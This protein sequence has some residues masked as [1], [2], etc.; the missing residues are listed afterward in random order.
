[1][2]VDEVM[3]K[4]VAE[5]KRYCRRQKGKPQDKMQELGRQGQE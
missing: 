2:K 1:M 5:D 3:R 4:K